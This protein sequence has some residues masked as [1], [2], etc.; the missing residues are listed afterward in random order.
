MLSTVEKLSEKLLFWVSERPN[1]GL[2]PA[3][4][5]SFS[6]FSPDLSPVMKTKFDVSEVDPT[7]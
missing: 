4:T 1:K 5:I 6:D 2:H 3:K 7:D